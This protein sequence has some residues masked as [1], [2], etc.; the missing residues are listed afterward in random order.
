MKHA[1]GERVLFADADGASRFADLELLQDAMDQAVASDGHAMVV[2]S[3]AHL[4]N[5]D[6]VV[7]VRGVFQHLR[8]N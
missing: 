6:A 3:R 8:K 7:K 4:V 1:R 2:G 5:S